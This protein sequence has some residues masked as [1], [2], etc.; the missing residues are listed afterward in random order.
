LAGWLLTRLGTTHQGL[1]KRHSW[2][3]SATASLLVKSD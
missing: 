2:S 1:Q 3:R